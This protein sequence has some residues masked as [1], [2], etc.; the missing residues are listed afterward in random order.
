[1]TKFKDDAIYGEDYEQIAL[2]INQIIRRG[3]IERYFRP[4]GKMKDSV[5]A[6]PTLKSKLRLY[7]LRMSDKILV[8]GNGGVKSSRTYDE[9]PAL[10]GY[11]MTLQKFEELLRQGQRDGSVVITKN[12]IDTD[13]TFEI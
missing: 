12:S 8:I 6:L 9:D 3:A 11:V 13:K 1:M 2:F 10:S 4:E 5:V 7:C